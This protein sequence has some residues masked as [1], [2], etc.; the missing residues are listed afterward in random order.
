V[1]EEVRAQNQV[2]AEGSKAVAVGR[3]PRRG[4]EWDN[5]PCQQADN[6]HCEAGN[7]RFGVDIL[8]GLDILGSGGSTPDSLEVTEGSRRKVAAVPT[9]LIVIFDVTKTQTKQSLLNT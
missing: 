6:Q 7:R 8:Q 3:N 5:H 9:S 2:V 1:H 4:T